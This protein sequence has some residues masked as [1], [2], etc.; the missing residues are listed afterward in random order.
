MR[1]ACI[2]IGSNTTR[3]LV[4]EP[5]G[6]LLRE[7]RAER[8]FTRIG[9]T[10]HS[11]GSIP[12]EK[13][14]EV[15]AVVAAYAV[16]AR[17]EGASRV[18]AVATAAVRDAPNRADLLAA[19]RAEAGIEVD[20]LECEEEAR[21]AFLGA[22]GTCPGSASP[23]TD[24]ATRPVAVLDVGGG[25]TEIVV[26]LPGGTVSWVVSVPVGSSVLRI[27]RLGEE[28]VPDPEAL[29]R[30][31][32]RSATAFAAVQPPPVERAIAVGGSATSLGRLVGPVLSGPALATAVAELASCT[33]AEVTHRHELHPDR[34]RMLPAALMIL[35]AAG[36]ALRGV[37]LE[38][39]RGGVREGVVLEHLR[40]SGWSAPE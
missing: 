9:A 36:K 21:L 10:C 11:D 38:I 31:R 6:P 35:A 7:L 16:M 14:A 24:G 20:V 1:C 22:T 5:E 15:A 33:V 3:L 2:D 25:S 26:G 30:A 39:G 28:G 27:P 23:D 17:S 40:H 37:P 34:V 8:S 4:A 19:I 29:A 32:E 18:R 13:I 12:P